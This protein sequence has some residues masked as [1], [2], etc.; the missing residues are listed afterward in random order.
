MATYTTTLTLNAGATE[1]DFAVA[2]ISPLPT[3]Q[4]ELEAVL[5][6]TLPATNYDFSSTL[7]PNI[8]Q[9]GSPPYT[10]SLLSTTAG[11]GSVYNDG[12]Y[13][14]YGS[15]TDSDSSLFYDSNAY[16]LNTTAIDAGIPLMPQTTG[17][18][19]ATYNAAVVIRQD[20][21]DYFDAEDY[22]NT[23]IWI[24]YLTNLLAGVTAG[25]ALVPLATLPAAVTI[26][27][28]LADTTAVFPTAFG[29]YNV[30]TNTLLSE[31]YPYTWAFAPNSAVS[32][33]NNTTQTIVYPDGVY[34]DYVSVLCTFDDEGNYPAL[35][36]EGTSYLL[37]TTTV[38]A[39]VTLYGDNYDPT[40]EAE[41]IAY[42]S[43][44]ALQT[45]IDE[46]FAAEAYTEAND[47][48][49]QLQ[50]LLAGGTSIT[51][52]AN[53][54]APQSMVVY[55]E[56]LPAGT[57]T[58]ATGTIENTLT[59]VSATFNGFPSENT[60]LTTILNSEELGFGTDFPDG[61]YQLTVN[62]Y[63]DGLLFTSMCY[64]VVTT[65]WQ[66]CIDKAVG[67]KCGKLNVALQQSNL[68]NAVRIVAVYL[69]VNTANSLITEGNRV[70]SGCG[71][72]CK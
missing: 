31:E 63:V 33:N 14:F 34:T 47:L 41:A 18:E 72:G 57:Y 46:A 37:V 40:N 39:L 71:C 25:G 10:V 50:N 13:R 6:N 56:T 58:N 70:C 11:F 2:S 12:V 69:D 53:L 8:N 1:I 9:I 27:T 54:S 43:M 45:A 49:V 38:D 52:L 30:I 15:F 36:N 51:L 67:K 16:M 4:I 20:I 17:R 28:E 62:F 61:V 26:N 48:I 64:L 23:N 44:L 68:T 21:Q 66:C 29:Y 22:T 19:I 5:Y 3:D 35:L 59:G 55:F 42:A 7:F 65:D 24:T 32:Q 60:D